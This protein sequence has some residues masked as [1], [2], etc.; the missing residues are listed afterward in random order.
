VR[1]TGVMDGQLESDGGTNRPARP[2]WGRVLLGCGC[3]L[4]VLPVD[5][6]ATDWLSSEP[7][8]HWLARAVEVPAAAAPY[9]ILL[10]ILATYPNRRRLYV[11]FLLPVLV[12]TG[13]VHALKWAVGRARP[14]AGEGAL[15]FTPFAGTHPWNSFPSADAAAAGVLALLLGIYFPRARWVFY[16]LAGLVGLGRI[17]IRWH[18][19]SDVLGGYALAALI[20]FGCLRLLGPTFYQ[21]EP[22]P[23]RDACSP[24]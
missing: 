2:P 17:V 3:M 12:S 10:A 15:Q 23:P 24:G 19:P 13:A 20:V 11:G 6:R 14:L 7:V 18:Y 9:L 22:T 5:Q 8:Q 21:K 16:V 1:D 4:A